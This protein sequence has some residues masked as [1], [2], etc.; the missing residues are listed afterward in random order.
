MTPW[1]H[2]ASAPASWA[3]CAR[4]SCVER[5]RSDAGRA[6]GVVQ[7]GLGSAP[8]VKAPETQVAP[9]LRCLTAAARRALGHPGL[10]RAHAAVLLGFLPA[11]DSQEPRER[12]GEGRRRWRTLGVGTTLAYPE[13]DA[14][15]VSLP[16]PPRARVRRPWARHTSRFTKAFEDQTAWLAVSC[17]QATVAGLMGIAWRTVGGICERVAAEAQVQR[18]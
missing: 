16:P 12:F 17:S 15:R 4:R 2:N 8:D 5:Q 6:C 18:V 13:G 10:M 11:R 9:P 7:L 14:P 1:M 3:S